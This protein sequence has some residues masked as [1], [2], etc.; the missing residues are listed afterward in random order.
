MTNESCYWVCTNA[1]TIN[2]LCGWVPNEISEFWMKYQFG[3]LW[4]FRYKFPP[5]LLAI[6]LHLAKAPSL[7][8]TLT[9]HTFFMKLGQ[10]KRGPC[11]HAT[12]LQFMLTVIAHFWR[13][14]DKPDL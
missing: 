13:I 11:S 14:F 7:H 4:N 9:F 8:G 3:V 5:F 10:V 2:G 6:I 12:L 1:V